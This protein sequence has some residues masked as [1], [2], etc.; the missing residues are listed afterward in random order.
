MNTEKLKEMKTAM[1][2]IKEL[3]DEA[4]RFQKIKENYIGYSKQLYALSD[5]LAI[6]AREMR[7]IAGEIDPVSTIRKP[8]VQMDVTEEMQEI[9]QGMKEKRLRVDVDLVESAYPRLA[10]NRSRLYSFLRRLGEMKGV[11]KTKEGRKT[12][13]YYDGD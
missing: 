4:V 9:Y 13:Y 12:I 2:S 8:R 5:S 7:K 11:R 1:K 10:D 3:H 6:L